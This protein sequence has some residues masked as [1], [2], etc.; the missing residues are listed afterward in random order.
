MIPS[1]STATTWI[2]SGPIASEDLQG[3]TVAIDFWTYTCINWRRTVPYLKSWVERYESAG[4][5]LIGVHSPE[6]EF[7]KDLDNVRQ[8]VRQI[9][10]E[11][12][13]AVDNNFA[14]WQAF[15]N[16]YWPAL[17][18]FDSQGRLRRQL[19]GEGE[20]EEAGELVRQLLGE[21]GQRELDAGPARIDARGAEVPADWEHL[22]SPENYLGWRRTENFGSPGGIVRGKPHLYS[23]PHE[24]VR[25]GWGL[26]GTWTV[27]VDRAIAGVA[28]GNIAYRFHAR[29]LHL[30]MG[31]QTRG[32]AIR[33]RVLLDGE[34]PGGAHGID[35]DRDG[36]G[37]LRDQR[38]YQ[39][40]RQPAAIE[41]CLFE[42]EFL[43]PGAATFCFTFG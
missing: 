33:F 21:A 1:L 35:V 24:T 28:G 14:I 41:D 9:G 29:D 26:S 7:E 18:I 43:E 4:L 23:L 5:V 31:P 17:Y 40:I 32:E 8:A 16:Q 11:Y 15:S 19:F 2:N 27:G 25:N 6:F 10:I 22:Q 20:Y 3:K 30:V 36:L 42:I 34:P 37:T 13:V 12:P 39:L 38:M